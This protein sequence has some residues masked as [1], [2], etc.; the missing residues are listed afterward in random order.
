LSTA[1]S[2]KKC[3]VWMNKFERNCN[4]S[5]IRCFCCRNKKRYHLNCKLYDTSNRSC[6]L[7]ACTVHTPLK[8]NKRE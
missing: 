2:S 1:K 4:S 8:S 7:M 5:E 6:K 3:K